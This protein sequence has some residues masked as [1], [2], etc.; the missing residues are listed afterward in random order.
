MSRY[1]ELP[2]EDPFHA[3]EYAASMLQGMQE[4]DDKGHPKMIA[5]VKHFTAYSQETGRG[6]ASTRAPPTYTAPFYNK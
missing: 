2:G 4:E 3:G 1:S 6:Y 5:L